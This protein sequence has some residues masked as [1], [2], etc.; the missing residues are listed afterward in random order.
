MVTSNYIKLLDNPLT[1]NLLCFIKARQYSNVSGLQTRI[2]YDKCYVHQI[3]RLY[4]ANWK[5]IYKNLKQ[6]LKEFVI[7]WFY[8]YRPEK[9][10]TILDIGAGIGIDTILFSKCVGAL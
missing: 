9:G 6:E 8:D 1:R 3:D 2:F 7:N 10:D 4:Y 5:P